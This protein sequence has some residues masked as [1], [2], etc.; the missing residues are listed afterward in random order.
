MSHNLLK[1]PA[2]TV[3]A[4]NCTTED[5]TLHCGA[6]YVSASNPFRLIRLADSRATF[7]VELPPELVNS[8]QAIA[9]WNVPLQLVGTTNA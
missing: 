3:Y 2:S 5:D 4:I 7:D 1:D 6:L 9:T 8:D